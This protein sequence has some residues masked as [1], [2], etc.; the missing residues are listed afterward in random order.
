MYGTVLKVLS[1]FV[2]VLVLN[3]YFL[4][5]QTQHY[6][7]VA[8]AQDSGRP[9]L[10]GTVTVYINV[11]DLNDNAPVF[12][13]MSFSNE[14]SEDI[15]VGSSIVTISATDLDSGNFK[16]TI[17]RLHLFPGIFLIRRYDASVVTLSL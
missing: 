11:V 17:Q 7:L 1:N 5:L 14:V 16:Q 3:G 15:A 8:Q 4:V 12:D 6:I 9:S 2:P 13:P 10:S